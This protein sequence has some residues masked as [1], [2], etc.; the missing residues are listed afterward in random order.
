MSDDE[1]LSTRS[2]IAFLSASTRS[3]ID[4]LP[5]LIDSMWRINPPNPGNS[6]A[7]R[8]IE[9]NCMALGRPDYG[10]DIDAHSLVVECAGKVVAA[11]YEPAFISHSRID[12]LKDFRH[13][14]PLLLS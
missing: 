6:S 11:K 4:H 9:S 3:L 5:E 12:D 8:H 14:L 13:F 1:P 2:L 7:N 10:M